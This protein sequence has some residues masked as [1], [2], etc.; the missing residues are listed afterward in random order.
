[1]QGYNPR[2]LMTG[3]DAEFAEATRAAVAKVD[4]AVLAA[5]AAAV[6]GVDAVGELE[7]LRQPLLGL[8]AAR[9][10]LVPPRCAAEIAAIEPGAT[11]VTVDAPHLVLQARP[12][13]CWRAIAPFLAEMGRVAALSCPVGMARCPAAFV[14]AR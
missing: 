7:R 11:M 14:T 1:M 10:R 6:L 3:G 8:R 5:R 12:S 2:W 9:D 4:R 13:E